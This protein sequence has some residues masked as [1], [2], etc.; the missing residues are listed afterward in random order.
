MQLFRKC[1]ADAWGHSGQVG[2]IWRLAV[3]VPGGEEYAYPPRNPSPHPRPLN[4]AFPLG[5]GGVLRSEEGGGFRRKG[6]V[7]RGKKRRKKWTRK[8][9]SV[10]FHLVL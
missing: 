7:G 6:T 4:I 9:C 1:I 8:K 2:L 3:C 5:N 10:S